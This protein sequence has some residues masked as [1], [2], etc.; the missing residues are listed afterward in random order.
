MTGDLTITTTLSSRI[1]AADRA[2]SL[3]GF[4]DDLKLSKAERADIIDAQALQLIGTAQR[5][6]GDYDDA[7][8]S[9][10]AAHK[11]AIAV[12]D[13]RVI[14]ITRLRSQ[15]L[16]DLGLIEEARGDLADAEA[17]FRGALDL[18]A[19]QYPETRAMNGARA[20]LASY[21]ARR[22]GT[23]EAKQLY[24]IVVESS[25]GQR[26]AI[27]G[28]ENQL[29]PYF[30]MLAQNSPQSADSAV[31]FFRASQL[32][33]RPGVAET[34]AVLARELSGGS[35]D[36]A[37]LFRQ[38]TNISREIE[39]K[40]LRFATLSRMEQSGAVVAE[41]NDLASEI[42]R[43]EIEQQATLAELSQYP[44]YRAVA[45]SAMTI[46]DL[47][48]ALL[49][50]EAYVR[51]GIV[52]EDI[53]TLFIDS[54]SAAIH[55]SPM[56]ADEMLQSVTKI[57]ASISVFENG[58]NVTY[59]FDIEEARK[60][61]QALFG[62][63][64]DRLAGKKHLIFEPD[65]AMLQL[66]V[67][68]LVTDDASVT[69]YLAQA[70]A[71]DGDPFNFVGV[72]WLGRAID[73]STAVSAK[74]FADARKTPDSRGRGQY[75]GLGKN[76]PVST[77]TRAS[78][79]RSGGTG[80]TL[81]CSWPT[82]AWNRPISDAE[83]L[84]ARSI[85]GAAGTEVLTGSAF[86]DDT[87]K[88]RSDLTD[89]RILHFATHG[90]LTPPSPN[91]PAKPALLT[92]FGGGDSDGLLSFDEIFDLR[93][94]ADIV[95]LSA[96]D[97][98]G[99]ASVEATRAAGIVSGGGSALD[100]LVRSFIGAGSRSVLAS[101]W[102]APDDFQATERLI[103]GLFTLGKGQSIGKA[104]RESQD[105]LMDDPATSHPYYWAG[106]AIVGDAARPF[107]SSTVSA[108]GGMG[109]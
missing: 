71:A 102:P 93:L 3:M 39:R 100:G 23:T 22:G 81:D 59:P 50:D 103:G 52:G 15:I 72:A 31:K 27:V 105:I 7:E 12:R 62:D 37:R 24:E 68:L 56:S 20:R 89:F 30:R 44:K 53:Y 55:R 17:F 73:V 32:L 75:L 84:Q 16:S 51:L 21:L 6:E 13:G 40:R 57:R 107:L 66:P 10:N 33:V 18:L 41:R 79:V 48:A 47:R 76:V 64:S 83:L 45:S 28:L 63:I 86:T 54:G 9:L 1:N 14:T 65:G 94:D 38:S 29:A 69:R 80:E 99:Q 108:A 97:T 77:L 106:F 91:C 98:A 78:S 109:E 96:C 87:I 8:L 88:G 36:A 2:A 46:D 60:L 95:I 67:N 82:S 26:G 61:Y 74:A 49:A 11:R 19:V 35:D 43:L 25:L 42:D 92:S 90:L 104:L 85:I 4:V 58:Q 5:L 34:Q 70:D 101:H